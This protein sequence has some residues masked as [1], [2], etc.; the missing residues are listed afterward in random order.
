MLAGG[1]THGQTVF[2]LVFTNLFVS[3]LLVVVLSICYSQRK[4]YKREL[5]AA[6][7]HAYGKHFKTFA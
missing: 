5:R 1:F 4:V 3:T 6:C 7:V 2:W